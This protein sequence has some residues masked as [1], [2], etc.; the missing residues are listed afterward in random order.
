M[1]SLVGGREVGT[2]DDGITTG[3]VCVNV[4]IVDEN[5]Q[6]SG[7]PAEEY[8]GQKPQDYEAGNAELEAKQNAESQVTELEGEAD[9]DQDSEPEDD[10]VGFGSRSTSPRIV[11]QMFTEAKRLEM[12]L[13]GLWDDRN[14]RR[15][16]KGAE[17]EARAEN[18]LKMRGWVVN[19]TEDDETDENGGI[20]DRL[21]KV[22]EH[23]TRAED[24]QYRREAEKKRAGQGKRM[25]RKDMVGGEDD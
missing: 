17:R 8:G 1:M 24:Q 10:Y 2:E 22:W 16:R 7:K 12:D 25:R 6:P 21:N 19:E 18:T 20:Q 13:E 14:T 5:L 15:T 3:W 4:G 9:F 23:K 11:V